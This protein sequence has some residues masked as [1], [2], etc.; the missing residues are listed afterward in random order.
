MASV[1]TPEKEYE[2]SPFQGYTE[3]PLVSLKEAVEPLCAAVRDIDK[4]L[5]RV[6]QQCSEIQ[7]DLSAD[8]LG[9]ILLYTLAWE[10]PQSSF[11][12]ILNRTIRS[13]VQESLRPWFLY[14]RLFINALSKLPSIPFHTVYRG[15]TE[16]LLDDYSDGERIIW[17]NFVSC[18]A[19]LKLV[20]ES[21]SEDDLRTI[22]IIECDMAKDISKYSEKENEILLYPARQFQVISTLQSND[23]LRLIQLCEIQ[24]Q[25]PLI[26][27][28]SVI[29]NEQPKLLPSK[30]RL[31]Y[32]INQYPG[33][34][35]ITLIKQKVTDADMPMI[36]KDAIKKKKCRALLL[37]ENSITAAG[38]LVLNTELKTNKSLEF[39]SLSCNR[40]CDKGV[41]S[42]ANVLA[43][44][45]SR[46]TALSLHSTNIT[47]KSVQ[48]LCDMLEINKCLTWL[49]L[50]MNKISNEGVK[51]IANTLA[52]RNKTLEALDLSKN[53][54]I[55]DSCIDF[56]EEM[57]KNEITLNT[58]WI[59]HCKLTPDGNNRL[60]KIVRSCR[61]FFILTV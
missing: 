47:D 21:C 45:V 37:S 18:K 36:V 5:R 49:H 4:M 25:R 53:A 15:S 35:Q 20:K 26:E 19:S 59:H 38:L 6:Q 48:H 46:I 16:N 1:V 58:L 51:L 12:S 14:L 55:D 33:Q 34:D 50:G 17:W 11:R 13:L 2:V 44:N 32:L 57:F 7:D 41:I 29:V 42:L 22:L 8:E 31:E 3:Q 30:S 39:L 52:H 28:A 10:K 9:S 40:L 61:R 23:R 27:I 24:S 43:A 60:H 56:L 54:A